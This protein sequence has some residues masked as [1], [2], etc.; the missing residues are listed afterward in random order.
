MFVPVG[1]SLLLVEIPLTDT[2]VVTGPGGAG[3]LG[4]TVR[5][6]ALVD[7]LRPL[8]GAVSPS[9][10][11]DQSSQALDT[12]IANSSDILSRGML[13]PG[14][15]CDSTSVGVAFTG[16]TPYAGALPLATNPCPADAGTD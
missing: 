2:F 7:A 10:C 3:M 16:T 5:T 8:W 9:L 1:H 11:S 4:S 12:A 15:T 6:S 14:E 13:A